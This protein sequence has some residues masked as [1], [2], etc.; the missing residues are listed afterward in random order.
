M[1]ISTLIWLIAIGLPAAAA[2]G[3]E[4]DPTV[5]AD[6]DE[7][8]R[9]SGVRGMLESLP[10]H[11][12]EMTA[13]AVAQFPKEQ[14]R[15]YEPLIQDAS[16]KFLDPEEFY[17][18]LRTYFA[19]HYDAARMSTFLALERTPV[20]RSMHRLEEMADTPAA[21]VSRRRFEANLKSDPPPPARVSVLQRLDDAR[22]STAL[23]VR[24][25]TGIV[26]AVSVGLGPQMPV[27]MQTQCASFTTKTQPILANNVLAGNLY[28]YRNVEDADLEDYIAAA[29]EKDVQW[30]NHNLQDAILAVVTERSV[31][32]GESI[33]AK[34][35][36]AVPPPN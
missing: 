23:Q 7:A 2:I 15:Q 10:S 32:A 28:T 31:R 26:S 11:I 9:L 17:R 30:F 12:N 24:I 14:R 29:Q 35:A 13:A 25:V 5:L 33:K 34:L 22:S 27:D 20:Y 21:Q 6:I 36:K 3:A 4:P 18:Q 8:F 16:L 1:R 19:K